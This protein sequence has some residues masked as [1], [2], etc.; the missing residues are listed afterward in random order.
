MILEPLRALRRHAV[1]RSIPFLH[2]VIGVR[3]DTEV[4]LLRARS[5]LANAQN[6]IE[7]LVADAEDERHALALRSAFENGRAEGRAELERW[8]LRMSAL[9]GRIRH[10]VD[11]LQGSLTVPEIDEL[12]RVRGLGPLSPVKKQGD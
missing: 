6:R 12:R 5:E 2:R 1:D 4:E 8:I 10:A 3:D 11:T 9:E 7:A